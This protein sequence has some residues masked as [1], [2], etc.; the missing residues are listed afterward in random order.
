[1]ALNDTDRANIRALQDKMDELRAV[2]NEIS[3]AKARLR[4]L[5]IDPWESEGAHDASQGTFAAL[6]AASRLNSISFERLESR[7]NEIRR[8]AYEDTNRGGGRNEGG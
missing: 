7:V 5:N 3:E 6:E 1:M 2:R 8:R 4:R